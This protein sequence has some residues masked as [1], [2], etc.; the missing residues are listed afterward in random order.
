MSN[1]IAYEVYAGEFCKSKHQSYV[2]GQR[3]SALLVCIVQKVKEPPAGYP[4]AN[5]AD[6]IVRLS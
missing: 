2:R 6:K 5:N 3:L 4:S 1:V